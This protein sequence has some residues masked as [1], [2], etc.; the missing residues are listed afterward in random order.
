[1]SE[2][3]KGYI[4]EM[5]LELNE[6]VTDIVNHS[7]SPAAAV[8]TITEVVSSKIAASSEGYMVD[9]YRE[10]SR[11]TLSEEVFQNS[12]NANKFYELNMR[13]RISE[14][15]HFDV[16]DLKTCDTGIDFKEINRVYASAGVATG[17]AAVG[18]IL[19]GA[20][21]GLVDLPMVVIIAG[22]ILSGIGG[23]AVTYVKIVPEKNKS[24]LKVAVG[25][26]MR[27]LETEL[28]NWVDAV[29]GFY[30]QTV[31]EFKASL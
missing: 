9:L 19:L 15:Y 14:A 4:K 29:E 3:V 6:G 2:K 25:K 28:L 7:V 1:M 22:A 12:A 20:L 24:N 11:K 16:Q 30:H 10:L 27:E 17:S 8:H 23:G 5:F 13:K 21:S 26:F 18:G 31:N